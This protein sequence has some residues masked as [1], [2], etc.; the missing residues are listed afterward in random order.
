M[1]ALNVSDTNLSKYRNE[2]LFITKNRN[3][4]LIEFF[5]EKGDSIGAHTH[6]YGEDCASVLS[7]ELSYY[8]SNKE[9]ITVRQ[10]EVVFGWKDVIHGYL[11]ENDVPVHMIVFATPEEIGL[12][13]PDDSDERVVHLPLNQRM[14]KISDGEKVRNSEYSSFEFININGKYFEQMEPGYTKAYI[15]FASKHIYLFEE[16]DVELEL[17]QGKD[18]LKYKVK[19]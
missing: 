3:A 4:R 11:N 14:L 10:G 17:P 2:Y 13:Y 1:Q 6:P 18:L 15:D 8:I 12:A 16:E 19:S 5:L 7:G 9:L